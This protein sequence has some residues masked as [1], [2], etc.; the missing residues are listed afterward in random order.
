MG[1]IP[2]GV[3]PLTPA[4]GLLL[5]GKEEECSFMT[6][7]KLFIANLDKSFHPNALLT[8][9]LGGCSINCFSTVRNGSE[10]VPI[11]YSNC[12]FRI[13]GYFTW[14]GDV[15]YSCQVFWGAPWAG[16]PPPLLEAR[17][18][19]VGPTLPFDPPLGPV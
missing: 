8:R 3:A 5:P 18:T 1:L 9:L 4:C 15:Y 17:G 13:V 2:K 12:S 10:F 11:K 16:G 19:A 14:L 6:S 7:R